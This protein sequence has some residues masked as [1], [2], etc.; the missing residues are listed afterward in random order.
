M[1]KAMQK[2]DFLTIPNFMSLF[3]ILLIPLIVWLYCD[4]QN[5]I[6]AV[7]MIALS[8]LTDI[9]DGKVARR[10]NMISDVGKVLD[11]VADKLTQAALIIC[12]VAKYKWTLGLIILFIVR[13]AIMGLL[14][15]IALTETQSVNG[16]KWYGKATTALIYASMMILILFPNIPVR[17]A[18]LMIAACAS[19]I[20][21]T[22]CMYCRFYQKFL[23]GK[24]ETGYLRKNY[25][26]LLNAFL[27][28][29]WAVVIVLCICFRKSLTPEKI[30][31]MTP[32]N[33]FL[34][35]L[36]L[37]ALFALKSLTVVIYAPLLYAV[38]GLLFPLPAAITINLVGTLIMVTIP[39]EVGRA[40]G[41]GTEE[42]LVEKHPKLATIRE[43]R[44]TNHFYFV[45]MVRTIRIPTDLVSAYMGAVGIQYAEY[46]PASMLGMLPSMITFALMGT[47][48]H[49]V[50]SLPFI[51]SAT[52]QIAFMIVSVILFVNYQKKYQTRRASSTKKAQEGR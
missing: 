51:I 25:R 6:A 35:A 23:F 21:I 15:Y 29:V 32:A 3:R 39:Y 26:T 48:I 49:D 12:L 14:G 33:S 38:S 9:L 30:A 7:G 28:C 34:A 2:K 16:A 47:N 1:K 36:V 41:A 40:A 22:C 17:I 13:E 45:W 44:S 42:R 5:H 10:F 8:A 4:R 50:R 46:L 20:V 18:N 11:P 24:L 27:L 52:A 19:A 43:I 31:S 37:L